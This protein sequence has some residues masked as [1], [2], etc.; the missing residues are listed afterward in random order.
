MKQNCPHLTIFDAKGCYLFCFWII[1]EEV[2][3]CWLAHLQHLINYGWAETHSDSQ[4]VGALQAL[5]VPYNSSNSF[6][7]SSSSSDLTMEQNKFSIITLFPSNSNFQRIFNTS[8]IDVPLSSPI[9]CRIVY[10]INTASLSQHLFTHLQRLVSFYH[11]ACFEEI[12][13]VQAQSQ[14]GAATFVHDCSTF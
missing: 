2:P 7:L 1:R 14:C 13:F 6:Y 10:G 5:S 11:Q 3:L 4:S 8:Y 9:C 12:H